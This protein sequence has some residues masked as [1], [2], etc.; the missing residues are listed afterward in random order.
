MTVTTIDAGATTPRTVTVRMA[1]L[2]TVVLATIAAL[3][4]LGEAAADA[5]TAAPEAVTADWL[6]IAAGGEFTCGIRAPGRL[7]C[8]GDDG[9]GQLGNGPGDASQVPVQVAGGHTDW[10]GVDAGDLSA[11]ALRRTGRLYCWGYDATGQLG[12]DAAFAMRTRPTEVA[13]G[14]TDWSAAFSVGAEHACA[15]RTT[16]RLFCWG[17]DEFGQVGDGGATGN[18][19]TPVQVVAALEG[20]LT[21]WTSVS[22]GGAHTCARRQGGS[23]FCWGGDANGQLG[24]P[25]PGDDRF[26]PVEV[27]RFRNDWTGAVTTGIGHTCA[28]RRNGREYCW[29]SDAYGQL[30]NG[31]SAG[32]SSVPVEP[33]GPAGTVNAVEGGGLHSCLIT[34]GRRLF[35]WGSNE[36]GQLGSSTLGGP[37]GVPAQVFGNRTNWVQVSAGANHTCAITTGRRSFCWGRNSRGQLG[38]GTS[39]S[40][41][42]PAQ[43]GSQGDAA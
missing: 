22:A 35:C 10:V 8:W 13:G 27:G 42:R 24:V 43:V 32:A 40:R 30:G 34:S 4:P 39:S 26:G 16:G 6:D 15:R 38:D 1:V 2:V 14:R 23:L 9:V 11:C 25:Q 17:S 18:R 37:G 5:Q 31:P 21:D 28:R 20:V 29:G 3:A 36:F 33:I 19:P 7:Y 41:A 12:N